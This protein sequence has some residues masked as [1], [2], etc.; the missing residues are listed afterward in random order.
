MFLANLL[1]FFFFFL[2]VGRIALIC[3]IQLVFTSFLLC[4][5]SQS[6]SHNCIS[7]GSK[8]GQSVIYTKLARVWELFVSSPVVMYGHLTTILFDYFN[9]SSDGG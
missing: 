2:W 7:L 9:A 5:Q 8:S 6:H 4:R 3:R 1:F